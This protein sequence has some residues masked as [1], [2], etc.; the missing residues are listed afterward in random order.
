[1]TS[2]TRNGNTY[3]PIMYSKEVDLTDVSA[4]DVVVGPTIPA[5]T[6]LLGGGLEV[7]TAHTGTSTD[8]TLDVGITG[9]DVDVFVDGFDF[10]A[11]SVGDF[12]NSGVQTQTVVSTADT[13]DV[14]VATQT[15]TTTAGKVRV[16]AIGVDLTAP[17]APG[18]AA[19]GS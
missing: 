7:I 10:D 17:R 16:W 19:I 3:V 8:C 12:A 11:A 18:L 1:M 6:L 14:L 2:M 5:G 4:S 9:G 13:L 15:G